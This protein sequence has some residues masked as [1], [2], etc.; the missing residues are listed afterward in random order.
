M[1]FRGV[2]PLKTGPATR[3]L[4]AA[5]AGVGAGV[6][7]ATFG[8]AVGSW[9]RRPPGTARARA[10]FWERAKSV[11]PYVALQ[12]SNDIFLLPT[13]IDSKVFAVAAR[14]EFVVLER[15]CVLL[16][17]EGRLAE[18][19]GIVDV[20][21]HIGTTTISALSEGG[22][23]W[24]V[25]IEPD[26]VHLPVLRANLALNNL[27]ERVT[28]IGAGM[29]SRRWLGQPFLPGSR[30]EGSYRWMKGRL[31]E[32]PSVDTIS[33]ETVTLDGLVEAGLAD[34]ATTGLLWF[35]CA[36]CERRALESASVF[37]DQRVPIVFPLRREHFSEPNPLLER[38]T[39]TYEQVVD[40]RSPRLSDP[41][42][43]WAP[44]IRPARDLPGLLPERKKL[45]DV[46]LF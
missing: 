39:S 15:A 22:F 3:V 25:A 10:A 34:P 31:A 28:I 29:A 37:F 44:T 19:H 41:L 36:G 35:D 14:P 18:Q 5:T 32:E 20:G 16:R 26:P 6:F 24:A 23:A 8:R 13:E 33:V 40:L 38:L 4:L 9:A 1:P 46:L 17:A 12:H 11:T 30:K 42:S 43:T 27:D 21:A 45:T 7:A 2:V